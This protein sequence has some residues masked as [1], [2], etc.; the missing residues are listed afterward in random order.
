VVGTF[1]LVCGARPGRALNA[2]CGS[3]SCIFS[4]SWRP[5]LVVSILNV[6]RRPSVEKK[7]PFA[8]RR[9]FGGGL[10]YSTFL[11]RARRVL[12]G[13]SINLVVSS[14][15]LRLHL[16]LSV[17]LP[18]NSSECR[19][20]LYRWARPTYPASGSVLASDAPPPRAY[21]RARDDAIQRVGPHVFSVDQTKPTTSIQIRLPDGSRDL[22]RDSFFVW[23]TN[24]STCRVSSTFCAT[25]NGGPLQSSVIA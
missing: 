1:C 17:H 9:R 22:H 10:L 4:S 12:T 18:H 25:Q 5:S 13:S 14:P 19:V 23:L 11:R 20:L 16:H 15:I 2:R 3:F 21:K 24:V 8:R 7:S 6:P